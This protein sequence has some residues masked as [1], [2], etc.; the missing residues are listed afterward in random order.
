MDWA[1]SGM[2][3]SPGSRTL[4]AVR[5]SAGEVVRWCG[6]C[7]NHSLPSDVN[8]LAPLGGDAGE[9]VDHSPGDS[10]TVIAGRGVGRGLDDAHLRAE[11][12]PARLFASG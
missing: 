6:S 5:A 4:S 8:G 11:H 3:R 9:W 1:V 2:S 12:I 7:A 10:V